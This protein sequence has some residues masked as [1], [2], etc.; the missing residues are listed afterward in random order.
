ML[1]EIGAQ[2]LAD[3]VLGVVCGQL[4][5]LQLAQAPID[6]D[7]WRGTHLD[8]QVRAPRFH[9]GAQVRLD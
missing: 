6:T 5:G 4:R 8:V 1:D 7:P 2:D 9:K 3:H